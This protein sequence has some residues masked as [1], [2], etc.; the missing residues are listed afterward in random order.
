MEIFWKMM[1]NISRS[2]FISKWH[3][4]LKQGVTVQFP[5]QVGA[6]GGMVAG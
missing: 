5:W 6:G 2:F 4:R 1:M 3:L